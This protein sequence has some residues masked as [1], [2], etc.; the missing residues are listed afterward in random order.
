MHGW[1]LSL[2]CPRCRLQAQLPDFTLNQDKCSALQGIFASRNRAESW[3]VSSSARHSKS[4]H[5]S[6]ISIYTG[7]L[8]WE[9]PVGF[10]QCCPHTSHTTLE[11]Y[12]RGF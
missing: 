6:S 7:G 4:C 12:N 2:H 11:Q 10:C 5:F 1:K 3:D 9:T 8:G